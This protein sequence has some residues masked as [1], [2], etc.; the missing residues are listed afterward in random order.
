LNNEEGNFKGVDSFKWECIE[1]CYNDFLSREIELADP[2][3]IFTVGAS[4]ER[5]VRYLTK[6]SR[7]IQQ[8]PHPAG[9]FRKE[10]FKVLNFWLVLRALYKAD[11][12]E[13]EESKELTEIFLKKFEG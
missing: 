13:I 5:W 3:V 10:Y 11:I 9:F 2:F 12:I 1:N 6:D 7:F 8:L 4:V